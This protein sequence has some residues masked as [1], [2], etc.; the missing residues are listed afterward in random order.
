MS[1]P[2]FSISSKIIQAGAG[3]GKTTNLIKTFVENVKAFKK[4]HERYPRV[5]VSTFTR[6]ATQE[7]KERLYAQALKE[8]D[9]ELFDYLNKKS[10]VHIST[11]HGL[12][13][14]FL[15]RYGSK[16]GLNP[17]LKIIST[18]DAEKNLKRLVKR[19]FD[20][21]S[22][23]IDILDFLN[24]TEIA[25]GLNQV[26]ENSIVADDF[27]WDSVQSLKEKSAHT[28]K[29]LINA[30]AVISSQL[31]EAAESKSWI[32]YSGNFSATFSDYSSLEH[33]RDFLGRKPA[34]SEA[35]PSLDPALHEELLQFIDL[36][37][38]TLDQPLFNPERWAEFERIHHLFQKLSNDVLPIFIKNKMDSGSLTMADLE[39]ITVKVLKELPESGSAFA[40]EWDYWMVDEYQDTSPIQV[41]I[42]SH[43]IQKQP[44]FVVGDPQQ[45]IYLF[46]GARS[47]VFLN[48]IN[49]I[50][51]EGGTFDRLEKN[52]RSRHEL[53]HFF[54]YLFP[55][56]NPS[57]VTTGQGS[58]RKDENKPAAVIT[59]LPFEEEQKYSNEIR[60][61]LAQVKGLLDSGVRAE[62]IAILSRK[63]SLLEKFVQCAKDYKIPVQCPSISNYWRR[64]EILDLISLTH[65][66][67]NSYNQ[68]SL[69]T[70]LR[71]PWFFVS[72]SKL[73]DLMQPEKKSADT[74]LAWNR[75]CDLA[76]TDESF[77]K[78]IGF[79]QTLRDKAF[80]FGVSAALVEF[81][82]RSDFLG[83]D[84][85][86]DPTGR[87][88]ANIWKFITDIKSQEKRPG[89]NL[90]EFVDSILEA[91]NL[92]IDQAEQDAAP[93]VEPNR[94]TLLT[95]HASKGLQFEHV[96]V[97]GL[98]SDSLSARNQV[99]TFDEDSKI[100]SISLKNDE[101]KLLAS[102][103][104]QEATEKIKH[105]EAEESWRVFYVALTRAQETLWLSASEEARKKTWIK[106]LPLNLEEGDHQIDGA[107]YRVQKQSLELEQ[108]S[109]VANK[110]ESKVQPLDLLAKNVNTLQKASVTGSLTAKPQQQGVKQNLVAKAKAL[111]KAQYGTMAHK[112]F[113]SLAVRKGQKFATEENLQKALDFIYEVK[114]PPMEKILKVGHAEWGFS[115][116][117]DSKI[118]QGSIDLWAELEDAVYILD[119]KTGSSVYSE[120]A[121][122]QMAIYS[123]ALKRMRACSS[124]KPHIL[125]AIYPFEKTVLT[126]VISA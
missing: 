29:I 42:L 3:A 49:E 13:V 12:L 53:V 46:R 50:Q 4:Q 79:L 78:P 56:I 74:S 110:S 9:Q 101:G 82:M 98:G 21:N 114:N 80:Q 67:L 27:K 121:F 54:N 83:A 24:W 34:F 116:K 88:E 81:L 10:W 2:T 8:N 113:E 60:T 18:A 33:W 61:V 69:L 124:S 58:D 44:H 39:I 112:V 109:T 125:V 63:N 43:F 48:K 72:D 119:Y 84:R 103:V 23:L 22:E 123:D 111:E 95:I 91:E 36:V 17:E 25:E 20:R 77:K 51:K 120:S 26:Y 47:E 118:L 52:Y 105:R 122:E 107:F 41:F 6:K 38:N 90:I 99:F 71:S 108:I 100:F 1:S 75:A 66:L 65:F 68:H 45:S 106:N 31:Q 32:A 14:P 92:N 64:R 30:H 70:L 93:I 16:A 55:K 126:Q 5:V 87:R 94:V 73:C 57:F 62:K 104:A 15:S 35:K 19:S 115:V 96:F 28:F 11:L 37:D 59:L 86:I 102:P 76:K 89:Q 85:Q 7:L 117:I 97:V 40:R